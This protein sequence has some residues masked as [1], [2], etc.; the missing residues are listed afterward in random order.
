MTSIARAL[1]G[2]VDPNHQGSGALEQNHWQPLW[3]NVHTIALLDI[4]VVTPRFKLIF[5]VYKIWRFW[6]KNQMQNIISHFYYTGKNLWNVNNKKLSSFAQLTKKLPGIGCC[7]KENKLSMESFK[8]LSKMLSRI[9]RHKYLCY[10]LFYVF[11]IEL[12]VNFILGHPVCRLVRFEY[13][14]LILHLTPKSNIT[15]L[16]YLK[17]NPMCLKSINFFFIP[18]LTSTPLFYFFHRN[19]VM[20]M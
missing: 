8:N 4:L 10:F 6:L 20:T 15:R 3:I 13:L 17:N 9:H 7:G 5:G 12:C 11:F 16:W 1:W 19:M 2:F 14:R 18:S